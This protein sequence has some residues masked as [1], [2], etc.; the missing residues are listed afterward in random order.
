MES[1]GH[2]SSQHA[3]ST[4][5][6]ADEGRS[7][8]EPQTSQPPATVDANPHIVVPPYWQRHQRGESLISNDSRRLSNP[9]IKLVDNT[10]EPSEQSKGL[11]AKSA[12]IDEHVV[13]RGTAPGIGDYVVWTCKVETLNGGTIILRKRYLSHLQLHVAILLSP[14]RYSEFDKLRRNLV[15]TF[16][17]SEASIPPLPRKSV[18][19]KLNSLTGCNLFTHCVEVNSRKT[20]SKSGEKVYLTSLSP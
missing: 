8:D 1:T 17:R 7:A 9:F 10:D 2:S 4:P 6:V 13:V 18:V 14:S 19:R 16:P 20:F 15:K 11:W 3:L 12:Q 5:S